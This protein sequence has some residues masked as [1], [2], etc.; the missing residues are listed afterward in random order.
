MEGVEGEEESGGEEENGL[1]GLEDAGRDGVLMAHLLERINAERWR[2]FQTI[3]K[4]LRRDG[5]RAIAW[6]FELERSGAGARGAEQGEC[7]PFLS[8]PFK[9]VEAETRADDAGP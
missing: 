4:V 9:P 5:M 3:T 7:Y 8:N 6:V 2:E 1:G